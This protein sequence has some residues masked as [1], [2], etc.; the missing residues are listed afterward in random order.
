LNRLN[1]KKYQHSGLVYQKTIFILK[2]KLF[3]LFLI[4]QTQ[5]LAQDRTK[6]MLKKRGI[7]LN[8]YETAIASNLV[9]L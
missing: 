2:L 3:H 8:V 4:S 5:L 6:A 1:F 7:K 9:S